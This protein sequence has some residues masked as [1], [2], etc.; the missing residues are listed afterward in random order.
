MARIRINKF[1]DAKETFKDADFLAGRTMQR[2]H[3]V[4]PLDSHSKRIAFQNRMK[5]AR[6]RLG[7]NIKD[8]KLGILDKRFTVKPA[9]FNKG[10]ITVEP[11]LDIFGK[12]STIIGDVGL[13]QNIKTSNKTSR[14]SDLGAECFGVSDEPAPVEIIAPNPFRYAAVDLEA[15]TSCQLDDYV[16][17]PEIQHQTSSNVD[18]HAQADDEWIKDITPFGFGDQSLVGMGTIDSQIANLSSLVISEAGDDLLSDKDSYFNDISL[19]M[20]S[21]SPIQSPQNDFCVETPLSTDD[22]FDDLEL[23]TLIS[24]AHNQLYSYERSFQDNFDSRDDS[25]ANEQH[26]DCQDQY[27]SQY[28]SGSDMNTTN[29]TTILDAP[30]SMCS[31]SSCSTPFVFPDNRPGISFPFPLHLVDEYLVDPLA[32]CC[33]QL[34]RMFQNETAFIHLKQFGESL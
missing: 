33:R 21:I 6:I 24:R 14:P 28:E 16:Y 32:H 27:A 15:T 9:V 3:R 25:I 11:N 10:R 12:R 13:F 20:E 2:N 18:D 31:E 22:S 1:M 17:R 30:E 29:F 5:L 8:S 34:A 7:K 19:D 26:H 23:S 4:A